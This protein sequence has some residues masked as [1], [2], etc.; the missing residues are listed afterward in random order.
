MVVIQA[1]EHAS[2]GGLQ[3]I[4]PTL[5]FAL[6]LVIIVA[7][8]SATA[9]SVYAQQRVA[10]TIELGVQGMI[11]VDAL[12]E[13]NTATNKRAPPSRSTDSSGGTDSSGS[14][15]SSGGA[16]PSAGD[17]VVQVDLAETDMT[18]E[19]FRQSVT[20]M[21]DSETTDT[22]DDADDSTDR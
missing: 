9:S 1:A 2:G 19:E 20:N 13:V 16:E 17:T 7:F 8:I 3:G 11:G 5:I 22:T 10:N 12:Q 21:S 14:T 18:P 6:G 4:A 15:D